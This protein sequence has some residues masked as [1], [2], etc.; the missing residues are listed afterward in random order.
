MGHPT[1]LPTSHLQYSFQCSN[2]FSS[3]MYVLPYLSPNHSVSIEIYGSINIFMYVHIGAR[4]LFCENRIL[5]CMLQHAFHTDT[6][7]SHYIF[8]LTLHTHTI[9]FNIGDRNIIHDGFFI[10]KMWECIWEDYWGKVQ[11]FFYSVPFYLIC[12]SLYL[13]FPCEIPIPSTPCLW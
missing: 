9:V 11:S 4:I 12:L 5:L 6:L 1:P 13:S 2:K 7:I 8:V 3:L 10:H